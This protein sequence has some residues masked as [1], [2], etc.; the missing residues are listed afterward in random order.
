MTWLEQIQTSPSTK[1]RYKISLKVLCKVCRDKILGFVFKR[2]TSDVN[3]DRNLSMRPWVDP[4]WVSY[5]SRRLAFSLSLWLSQLILCRYSCNFPAVDFREPVFG[6]LFLLYLLRYS[7]LYDRV[8]M[9]EVVVNV[10]GKEA[11][12][13]CFSFLWP[14]LWCNYVLYPR[15]VQLLMVI[16]MFCLTMS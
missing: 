4:M 10:F 13:N 1:I 11:V 5:N 16:L 3:I 15:C 6:H 9:Y 2:N 12:V 7:P 14:G 8:C